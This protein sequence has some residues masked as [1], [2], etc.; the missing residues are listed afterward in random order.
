ME[1]KINYS[2]EALQDLANI[3]DYISIELSSP[4]AAYKILTEITETIDLLTNN[5]KMGAP[6]SSI[7]NTFSNYR[8]LLVKKI[9]CL[10]SNQRQCNLCFT[11]NI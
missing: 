4:Q 6:L 8:F 9:L 3:G 2:P 11:C 1:S 10:L 5:P 7:I